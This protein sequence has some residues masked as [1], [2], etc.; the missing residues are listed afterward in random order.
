MNLNEFKLDEPIKV[1]DVNV[2]QNSQTKR[3][4]VNDIKSLDDLEKQ[5]RYNK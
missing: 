4:S 2:I 1:I 3:P 5:L